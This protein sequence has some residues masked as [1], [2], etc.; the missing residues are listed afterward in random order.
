MPRGKPSTGEIV[1]PK[2]FASALRFALG[3]LR[4]QGK[5]LADR[6]GVSEVTV[7]RWLTG[8]MLPPPKRRRRVERAL[9]LKEGYLDRNPPEVDAEFENLTSKITALESAG[10]VRERDEAPLTPDEEQFRDFLRNIE[11]TSRAIIGDPTLWSAE[12][13]R[14][15]QL[16]VVRAIMRK[17]VEAGRPMPDWLPRIYE[18]LVSGTFR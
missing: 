17:A 4:V 18:E 16:G 15:N 5:E 1:S 12:E 11:R 3:R 8:K 13:H 7:S 2:V 9:G 10:F 6:L 14:I